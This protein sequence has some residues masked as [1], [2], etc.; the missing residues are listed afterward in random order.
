M[1]KK[2]IGFFSPLNVT[3]DGT[4]VSVLLA[5]NDLMTLLGREDL[6]ATEFEIEAGNVV[7]VIKIH[8]SIEEQEK[9]WLIVWVKII[10]FV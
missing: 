5:S 9:S 1:S 2:L 10:F 4:T 3:I 7:G 8:I 6:S